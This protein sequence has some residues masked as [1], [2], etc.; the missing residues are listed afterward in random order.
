MNQSILTRYSEARK[1]YGK[2][3]ID[4][5]KV[6]DKLSK[7]KISLHCWQGDD[8]RGFLNKDQ[9]L[10]GGISVTG[11]YPGAARNVLELRNDIEKALALIPG[12][13]KVNLH[14]IY[15]DTHEK[16]ELD[17]LEPKHFES[18]VKWAKENGLGLDFNP[19]CFS[20]PKSEDGFTLSNP[21][22]KIRDFW[23]KHCMACRKIGEYFGKEL[24][25][26]CVTNIWVPDGY[27][28]TP[29][30]R[31]E[32]R[33][34]LK[35]SL[36]EIFSQ[37][38][39]EKY[40]LDAVESKVF[41]IGSESYVVGSHEFYMGYA[42]KNNKAICLDAGHF[43]PTETISNK[44][45]S[46]LMFTDELLLHVSRPVRWDSDHIVIMSDELEE[47]AHELVRND[48]IKR[49]H[50]GLDFFDGSVNRIAAWVIGARNMIK[51]LLKAMLEPTEL[52]KKL[53]LEKDYTSRIVLLEEFKSYPFSDVWDYYCEKMDV[54]VREEWF[55]EVKQY[56]KDVLVKRK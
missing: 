36:D 56:E 27:K 31:L 25:Q 49:T 14:A 23:I 32:P 50:I 53:E 54:P 17:E 11:N 34:R 16:V 2:Y 52:L 37:N 42:I 45:S 26:K 40:N 9:E 5:D 48:L 35:D 30:D 4:V 8:V 10:T 12:K 51:A 39:D 22:K 46:V 28:D 47:I 13:H 24:G 21:D 29:I 38:V 43:H 20:H 19:T 55:D 41:G 15:A 1:L 7:I 33:K 18:W 6:L 3:D 44:I